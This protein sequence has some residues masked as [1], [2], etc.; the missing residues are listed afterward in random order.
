MDVKVKIQS[1]IENLDGAGLP[2]G[3][4]ERSDDTFLGR[5]EYA[6]GS[7]TLWY[8]E[9][10]ESGEVRSEIS[11]SDGVVTVKRSGA[12]ESI[13]VFKPGEEYD[14]LYSVPPYKFDVRLKPRKIGAEL[15]SEGGQVDLLYN[16]S[17]GGADKAVRMKIWIRTD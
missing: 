12:I 6:D 1:K 11:V 14:T 9:R 8:E 7:A 4:I 17:I 2:L 15:G 3:D 5:Y 16:M 13:F 10:G